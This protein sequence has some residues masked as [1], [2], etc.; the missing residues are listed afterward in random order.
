MNVNSVLLSDVRQNAASH[1]VS[2]KINIVVR[3]EVTASAR[4]KLIVLFLTDS[5]GTED[6]QNHHSQEIQEI[7][8]I[9]SYRP[10]TF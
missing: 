1:E 3:N 5:F 8:G 7:G 4:S 2:Q 9:L 10:H 6:N